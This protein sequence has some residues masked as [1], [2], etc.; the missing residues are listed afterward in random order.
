MPG[1]HYVLDGA[2]L[3]QATL[4]P[5][6]RSVKDTPEN[7]ATQQAVNKWI[8]AGEGFEGVIDFEK[9]VQ[10]PENPL[11]FRANLTGSGASSSPLIYP[12]A[13]NRP[14]AE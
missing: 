12:I 3:A 8:R 2:E 14:I 9:V 13:N 1:V 4:L 10:D 11:R 5:I 6:Q 7:L